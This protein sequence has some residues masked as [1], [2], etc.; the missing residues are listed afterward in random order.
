MKN[1]ITKVRPSSVSKGI[2]K[3]LVIGSARVQKLVT[4]KL[5]DMNTKEIKEMIEVSLPE[6]VKAVETENADTIILHQTAF[7]ENEIE[8]LGAA[9]KYAGYFNKN[10]TVII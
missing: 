2:A 9:I 10:I 4:S 8:L 6:F 3:P 5:K 7:S 1:R